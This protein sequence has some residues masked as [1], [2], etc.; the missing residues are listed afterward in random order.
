M[1]LLIVVRAFVSTG[2]WNLRLS[3]SNGCNYRPTSKKNV[4]LHVLKA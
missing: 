1:A 2:F 4:S 3:E